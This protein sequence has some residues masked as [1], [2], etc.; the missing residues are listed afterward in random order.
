MEVEKVVITVRPDRREGAQVGYGLLATKPGLGDRVEGYLERSPSARFHLAI[1]YP[2][3][4]RLGR[5]S[6]HGVTRKAALAAFEAF[7]V[8]ALKTV[9]VSRTETKP[10]SQSC[11]GFSQVGP[12]H[13]ATFVKCAYWAPN[14]ETDAR[15]H[16]STNSNH[17]NVESRPYDRVRR[18][19]SR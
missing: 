8:E 17:V 11:R 6:R 19:H 12:P 16:S 10:W 7:A 2:P 18:L 14:H 13:L 1:A 4:M 15:A 5:L 9:D 3:S